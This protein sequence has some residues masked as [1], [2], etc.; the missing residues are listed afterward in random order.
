MNNDPAS[1]ASMPPPEMPKVYYLPNLMTAGNLF[2][3]FMAVCQIIAGSVEQEAETTTW[4]ARY[5][6][7]LICILA[8]FIFDMLD[9]RLAR[10]GG[11][12]SSFGREF[13]SLA[14]VVSFGIAPALLVYK[15]ILADLPQ[16]Y[17][18]VGVFVAF[19][20]LAAGAMRLARFNIVSAQ[21]QPHGNKDFVGFP[22][23]AAAGLVASITLLILTLDRNEKDIGNWK[24][25]LPLLLIF[26]SF[27]MYS[28]ISY[29]SFKAIDWKA[30]RSIPQILI[31]LVIIGILCATWRYSLALVFVT[32]LVY[33]FI[34]PW[35]SKRIRHE[36][37]EE[38]E[39]EAEV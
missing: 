29:P 28:R 39:E 19:I 8:A 4:I 20:Y 15:I 27:M 13:D 14:D 18:M 12:E 2:C 25:L 21:P 37:E 26:L 36:I 7:S 9:G 33:G 11:R 22:I 6:T 16:K 32:Y 30:K 5:E 23:P 10:L 34:R 35:V 1:P 17:S 31:T 3:G 24:Y 38:D